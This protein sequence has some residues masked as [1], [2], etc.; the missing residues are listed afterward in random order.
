MLSERG[1]EKGASGVLREGTWG[2]CVA[3]GGKERGELKVAGM[4]RS[5]G[6]RYSLSFK[7]PWEW[8]SYSLPWGWC[9]LSG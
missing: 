8:R 6:N 1:E 5:I 7:C 3:P 4:C 2:C 9:F